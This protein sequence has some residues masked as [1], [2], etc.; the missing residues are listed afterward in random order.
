MLSSLELIRKQLPE[1]GNGQII[2]LVDVG[3]NVM[4]LTVL[5]DGQQLYARE[6]AFGGNQLTQ[7]IARLYGMTFE[8]AEAEKR[9][10]ALPD[11]YEAELLQPFVE[12]MALEVSRALQFFFTSTPH[13][14]VDHI[15]LAG[16]SAPL[17][18]LT[19]AVTQ[20]TGFAC[21]AVNPFD[22]MEIG[23]SVRLKKMVREAP[24][25]LTSCGLAMR[26]FLQ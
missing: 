9:R 6:Q 15:M 24:S 12:S 13:N 19:E 20:Q 25:Y 16:G 8:E 10:N 5:R 1:D 23:S 18:G 21:S 17:P 26:R 7:D 11:N 22:G 14:R 4:N 2:A 3:A